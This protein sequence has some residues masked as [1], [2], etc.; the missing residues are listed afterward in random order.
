[1]IR[2]QLDG[3][4]IRTDSQLQFSEIHFTGNW[5][6]THI[7]NLELLKMVDDWKVALRL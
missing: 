7:I 1:M 5:N 4:L 3:I 2:S 6:H